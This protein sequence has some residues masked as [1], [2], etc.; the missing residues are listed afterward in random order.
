MKRAC[1]HWGY[2]LPTPSD[3]RADE[4]RD[5]AGSTELI[6]RAARGQDVTEDS[7]KW[8]AQERER[9]RRNESM[10]AQL[11]RDGD[12]FR[13]GADAFRKAGSPGAAEALRYLLGFGSVGVHG[14]DEDVHL[15]MRADDTRV[16]LE[17]V[18]LAREWLVQQR[19]RPRLVGLAGGLGGGRR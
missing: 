5:I 16:R 12:L 2:G 10:R 8:L 3:N 18:K 1:R 15:Q 7:K 9:C 13:R 11:H 6:R 17:H 14:T 4:P 19:A